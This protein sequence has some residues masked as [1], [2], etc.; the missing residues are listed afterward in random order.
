MAQVFPGNEPGGPGNVKGNPSI[1][2]ESFPADLSTSSA[3]A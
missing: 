1:H 3:V 2:F